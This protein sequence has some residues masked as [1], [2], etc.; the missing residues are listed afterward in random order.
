VFVFFEKMKLAKKLCSSNV[1]HQLKYAQIYRYSQLEVTP[2][3][4]IIQYECYKPK[5]AA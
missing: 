3:F 2:N 5:G 1:N 4:K